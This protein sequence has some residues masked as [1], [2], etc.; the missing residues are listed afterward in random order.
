M[1]VLDEQ[2]EKL[3]GYEI[4]GDVRRGVDNVFTKGGYLSVWVD[5]FHS[6]IKRAELDS[7]KQHFKYI[8]DDLYDIRNNF[9]KLGFHLIEIYSRHFFIFDFFTYVDKYF[10]I[11]KS[12]AQKLMAV[13]RAYSDGGLNNPTPRIDKAYQGYKYTQ[14]ELMLSLPASERFK[15]KPQMTCDSIREFIKEYKDNQKDG[16]KNITGK[17]ENNDK[18]QMSYNKDVINYTNVIS[19]P[20][21]TCEAVPAVAECGVSSLTSVDLAF[22]SDDFIANLA[23]Y[24]L[25]NNPIH[26]DIGPARRRALVDFILTFEIDND[27]FNKLCNEFDFEG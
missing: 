3:E 20:E 19:E 13:C 22:R 21:I 7:I 15:V 25:D 24:L 14:L 17:V 5:G 16:V 18:L 1:E 9:I 8:A 27:Y 23:M 4:F 12:T 11:G 26:S 2:Y 6:Y 10:H